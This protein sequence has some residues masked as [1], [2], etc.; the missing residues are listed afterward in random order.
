MA[1]WK[2]ASSIV[3]TALLAGLA[4]VAGS[5]ARAD[6]FQAFHADRTVNRAEILDRCFPAQIAERQDFVCTLDRMKTAD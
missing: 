1:R 2:T 5:L 3:G 6:G 4:I